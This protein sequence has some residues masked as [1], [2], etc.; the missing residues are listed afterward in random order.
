MSDEKREEKP[1]ILLCWTGPN[2]PLSEIDPDDIRWLPWEEW[3]WWRQHHPPQPA[4]PLP[5][6]ATHI[7]ALC[8]PCRIHLQ[9]KDTRWEMYIVTY[10]DNRL[11]RR[12]DFASPYREH[13]QRTAELWY[14]PAPDGWRTEGTEEAAP[15]IIEDEPFL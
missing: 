10:P 3:L 12:K 1:W 8:G 13:A 15:L 7:S 5:P 9:K 2:I 4:P 11:V 6:N 14:G